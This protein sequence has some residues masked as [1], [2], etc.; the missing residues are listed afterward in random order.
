LTLF[1]RIKI[2]SGYV[3]FLYKKQTFAT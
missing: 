3:D 1:K 2:A